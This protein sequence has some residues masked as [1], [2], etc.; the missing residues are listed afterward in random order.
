[1]FLLRIRVEWRF[2]GVRETSE[3][4][5][6]STVSNKFSKGLSY[7]LPC[8]DPL[9][10]ISTLLALMPAATL[11]PATGPWNVDIAPAQSL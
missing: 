1:V 8:V 5:V 10:L 6:Y 3:T 2:G 9:K 4:V 11:P 7:A